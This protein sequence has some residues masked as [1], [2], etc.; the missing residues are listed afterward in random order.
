MDRERIEALQATAMFGALSDAAVALLL[1]RARL[2]RVRAGEPFFEQDE[3]GRSAVLLERGRASVVKRWAGREHVLRHLGPGDCFG[4]VALLDFGPRSATVRA[5]VDCEAL[6]LGAGD[7][8][9]LGKHDPEQFAVVY[10]NLGRELSRRLRDADAR[11]FETR[12]AE[13]GADASCG[14]EFSIV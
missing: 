7:L 4:E 1:E 3:P 6:E 5:D 12:M 11:L 14:E 9:V 8:R 10:M 2:R 13:P